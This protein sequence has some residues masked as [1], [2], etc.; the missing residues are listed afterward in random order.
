MKI[1]ILGFHEDDA[2]YKVRTPW[3]GQI[4]QFRR[5]DAY[6]PGE[7]G[8]D[9]WSGVFVGDE[10]GFGGHFLGVRFETLPA[11]GLVIPLTPGDLRIVDT[12]QNDIYI[13]LVERYMWTEST[14]NEHWALVAAFVTR[15]DAE[16]FLRHCMRPFVGTGSPVVDERKERASRPL[17]TNDD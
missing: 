2:Y 3:I 8:K 14:R 13:A 4:G 11:K 17:E 12:D 5:K 6:A 7:D 9:F 1:K 10:P 16:L 15:A